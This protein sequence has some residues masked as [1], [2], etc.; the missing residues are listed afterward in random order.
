MAI[1]KAM[2]CGRTVCSFMSGQNCGTSCISKGFVAMVPAILI[3]TFAWTLCGM[4]GALGAAEY[5][6]GLVQTS[7]AGLMNMLPAIIFLVAIGLSF[8]T[9]TSW[10][11]FGILIP[12]RFHN[13]PLPVPRNDSLWFYNRQLEKGKLP[14]KLEKWIQAQLAQQRPFLLF[15]PTIQLMEKSKPLFQQLCPTIESVHAE[16]P[17]RKEK[18]MQLREEKVP[19]LMTTTILEHLRPLMIRANLR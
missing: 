18:V 2:K 4:T 7:A 19:G 11:T 12:K 13:Y 8:A 17:D 9:G 14:K 10:G 15:F 5:V 16:D 3:L 1:G 6:A